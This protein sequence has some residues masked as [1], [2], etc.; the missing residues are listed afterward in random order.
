MLSPDDIL[1]LVLQYTKTEGKTTGQDERDALFAKLFAFHSLALSGVLFLGSSEGG[2]GSLQTFQRAIEILL[3][4]A[5]KKTWLSETCAWSLIEIVNS[6][7]KEGGK[8]SS[9]SAGFN[10]EEAVRWLQE[11]IFS[12][13]GSKEGAAAGAA[14]ALTCDKLA[15]LLSMQYGEQGRLSQSEQQRWKELVAP[16]LKHPN[17]LH[18]S[19]VKLLARVL[20]NAAL[21]GSEG[22]E[23]DQI[24]AEDNAE[25]SM[26][27]KGKN[28]ASD[29]DGGGGA[30]KPELPLAWR[31]IIDAYFSDAAPASKL[32]ENA[33]FSELF[34]V[35]VE[36]TLF[37]PSASLERKLWGFQIFQLALTKLASMKS[38]SI[39]VEK[40]RQEVEALFGPNFM[41]S[42]I[43]H[44]SKKDRFLHAAAV[45]T[46]Q[47]AQAAAKLDPSLGFLLISQIVGKNGH[48]SFDK[49]TNSK[50]V[51]GLLAHL[52]LQGVK[53]Y[54]RHLAD[55]ACADANTSGQRS[56]EQQANPAA[57]LDGRRKWA[58]DQMLLL[59]RQTAIKKDDAIVLSILA[60]L[61]AQG[62]AQQSK[63]FDGSADASTKM[64]LSSVPK[65]PFSKDVQEAC[66]SRF[67]SCL[68]E[69]ID[70][71][72]TLTPASSG[73]APQKVQGAMS[74]G[75][76]WVCRAVEIY[77]EIKNDRKHFKWLASQEEEE[78]LSSALAETQKAVSK[79]RKTTSKSGKDSASVEQAKA[80]ESLLC[81]GL[82]FCAKEQEKT[83]EILSSVL[84]AYEALYNDGARDE[85]SPSGTDVLIDAIISCLEQPSAFI[86]SAALQ[87]FAIFSSTMDASAIDHIIDQLG[88][89]DEQEADAEM[90]EEEDGEA[91]GV[92]ADAMEL[93][94]ED[95]MTS[96]TSDSDAEDEA[97]AGEVD[98]ILRQK[99]QDAL[100]EANLA[101]DDDDEEADG[102]DG[103]DSSESSVEMSDFDDDEM[104][105][106]DEKLGE[107]FKIQVSTK[108]AA[109]SESLRKSTF[110]VKVADQRLTRTADAKADA[111]AFQNRLLDLL[112]VFA[113]KQSGD[114][115]LLKLFKPLLQIVKESEKDEQQ[116]KNKA[117]GLLQNRISKAKEVMKIASSE[118][119]LD[120]LRYIHMEVRDATDKQLSSLC[121]NANLYLT[122]SLLAA[123]SPSVMPQVSEVYNATLADFIERKQ[124]SVKPAF[125]LDTFQ[126]FPAIGWSLRDQIL[127]ACK[128]GNSARAFRQVQAFQFLQSVLTQQVHSVSLPPYTVLTCID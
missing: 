38:G 9:A 70:Q 106:L 34:R 37:G 11:R 118:E 85:D 21:V 54:L 55:V 116:I 31:L 113:R 104:M 33:P 50:T 44:L 127:T 66:R 112:D 108:K 43:N 28:K 83:E 103:D 111:L 71:T 121:S 15:L 72:T 29:K 24:G 81:A 69:L 4:T 61:A 49:I 7:R 30:W 17:V 115:L 79:L 8:Q 94:S 92:H 62:F 99:V 110:A 65:P 60:F 39:S 26:S 117:S 100:K 2:D 12:R 96:E 19:N 63:A 84:N 18:A 22:E 25:A 23:G 90:A 86:R 47:T 64:L 76:K 75:K 80:L 123:A 41:R 6:L 1:T 120:A 88:V 98:P 105:A 67:L 93:G 124:S 122:K 68:G 119:A 5:N 32:K 35:A 36:E 107:I 78:K 73:A 59:V 53:D 74:T 58:L 46:V 42:W 89:G 77:L 10:N 125:L 14:S 52:D 40:K 82:L 91:G 114:A 95:E 20:K 3:A 51:E 48:Q 128:P 101:E 109:E 45:R 57:S 102:A 126:R 97:N 27:Q 56:E 16:P 87:T 13:K